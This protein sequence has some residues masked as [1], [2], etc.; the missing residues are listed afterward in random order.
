MVYGVI[1]V[2]VVCFDFDGTLVDSYTCLPDVYRKLCQA[3]GLSSS[4]ADV[5]VAE[6]MELEDLKEVEEDYRRELWWGRYF[7]DRWGLELSSA[8]LSRLHLMWFEW[9]TQ[10]TTV[11]DCALDVL[12]RLKEAGFKVYIVCGSDV[13]PGVKRRRVEAS[14]LLAATDGLYVAHEDFDGCVVDKAIELASAH[15]AVP[16]VVDDKPRR[17]SK[18]VD[19]GARAILVRFTGPL[20]RVWCEPYPPEVTVVDRLCDVLDVVLGSGV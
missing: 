11:V 12:L 10:L 15:G 9:R 7:S 19:R 4:Q 20:K 2:G 3:V 16:Y 8:E 17:V 1:L 6:L 14:G 18:A 13:I 5:A